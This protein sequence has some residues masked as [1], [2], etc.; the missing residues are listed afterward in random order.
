MHCSLL[1]I[2]TCSFALSYPN[3]QNK[4]DSLQKCNLTNHARGV[5]I[6]NSTR[7]CTS[8]KRNAW[9]I[10]IAKEYTA[11][12]WWDTIAFAMN[13]KRPSLSAW[14]FLERITGLEPAT[15]TLARWRSTK[16]A[17]SAWHIFSKNG[18]SDGA[19]LSRELRAQSFAA[20][21]VINCHSLP[22]LLLAL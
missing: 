1:S 18:D 19:R 3:C 21:T 13:K 4:K 6:I 8:S 11:Y 16:W 17:K 5:Y 12:G 2:Y 7:N 9:Y 10:I 20:L 22:L 14:S 15:S